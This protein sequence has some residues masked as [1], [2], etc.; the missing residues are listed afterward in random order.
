MRRT[1]TPNTRVR[2][3]ITA[4]VRTDTHSNLFF[5][6]FS[7]NEKYVGSSPARPANGSVAQLEECKKV[8]SFGGV[9]EWFMAV[10]LKASEG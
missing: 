1:S 4:L 5:F 6:I 2:I 7:C 10:A 8:S 9:A 3:S